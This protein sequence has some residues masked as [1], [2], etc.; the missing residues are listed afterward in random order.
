MYKLNEKLNNIIWVQFSKVNIVNIYK[1]FG[2]LLATEV[3]SDF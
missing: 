3:K 1:I 2:C